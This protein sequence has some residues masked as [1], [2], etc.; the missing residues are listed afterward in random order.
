[1]MA[2]SKRL[3]L[4]W[5]QENLAVGGAFTRNAVL[6]LAQSGVRHVLDTREDS[7][8]EPNV[9]T[10]HGIDF[11]HIPIADTAKLAL[12]A[13]ARASQWVVPRLASGDKVL[14][15]CEHGMGR[16]VL[17]GLCLLVRLGAQPTEALLQMKQARPSASPSPRQLE[18]F[19]AWSVQLSK[20]TPSWDDLARIAYS[21]ALSLPPQ[22]FARAQA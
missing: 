5:V 21:S 4:C 11:I 12:P 6:R 16:S 19:I 8:D 10:A 15:H 7:N 13:I 1:M 20:R 17:L 18:T 22:P 14:V 3:D 2:D 9:L